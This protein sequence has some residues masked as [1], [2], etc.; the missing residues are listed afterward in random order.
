LDVQ[1]LYLSKLD[2]GLSPRTVQI[3]HATLHK[4]GKQAVSWSLVSKNVTEALTP[5]SLRRRI[6]DPE[7]GGGERASP[8]GEGGKFEAL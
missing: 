6:F 5:Q 8:S 4:A 2:S 3:I 7:P 1:E